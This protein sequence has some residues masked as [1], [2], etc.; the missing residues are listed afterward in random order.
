VTSAGS[1]RGSARMMGRSLRGAKP[2]RRSRR[3]S[4]TSAPSA[5]A[6]AS[7]AAIS[8][9]ARAVA[10]TQ[11]SVRGRATAVAAGDT[12]DTDIAV[13]IAV[14]GEGRGRGRRGFSCRL[15]CT[16]GWWWTWGAAGGEWR[17]AGVA[18]GP[19]GSRGG[20]RVARPDWYGP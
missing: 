5:A 10:G 6:A 19:L 16:L 4:A 14:V 13:A 9:G 20:S 12:A 3:S 7:S 8:R 17:C 18:L 1:G 15:H 11:T 2:A